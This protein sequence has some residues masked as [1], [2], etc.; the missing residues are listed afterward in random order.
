MGDDGGVNGDG[1]DG[2]DGD[3]DKMRI[4]REAPLSPPTAIRVASPKRARACS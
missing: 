4:F 1:D 2:D 3:G